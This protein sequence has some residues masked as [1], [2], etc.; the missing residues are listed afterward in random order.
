MKKVFPFILL[1]LGVLAIGYLIQRNGRVATQGENN[2]LRVTASFYPL[3]FFA[4]TIGGSATNVY[5]MTPLG[6]EPHDYEPT[7]SDLARI[8]DGRLLI[9]NGVGLEP[10]G[11]RIN[12][13]V[14]GKNVTV[15]KAAEGI[16]TKK[17]T[18][19]GEEV[20]DPHVWLDP[21]LAKEEVK[22]ITEAFMEVDTQNSSWYQ[23]NARELV[24]ELDQLDQDFK[25]GLSNCKQKNIVTS[26]AAFGYLASRYGLK[27]VS[28]TGLSPDEEPA[29]RQMAEVAKFVKQN[30]IKYIFFE[31]LVS[32]KLSETIAME[33]GAG[34]L[35][36]NPLEGL[37]EDQE[38]RGED[39][40]SVQKENLKNLRIALSCN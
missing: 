20:Q 30:E 5:N 6:V 3:Y 35:V 17:M 23:S 40:F 12:D 8:V 28:V 7:T 22:K 4:K 31:E 36:F 33:T 16:A 29:A 10:W 13:I 27:Q 37:T 2:N 26:H 21:I 34:V 24:H 32:P 19:E 38:K 11:D 9:I 1:L 39:Y 15:V 18:E 25:T 14:K